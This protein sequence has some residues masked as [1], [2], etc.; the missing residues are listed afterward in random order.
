MQTRESIPAYDN[1]TL[2]ESRREKQNGDISH[3]LA[4]HYVPP[5]PQTHIALLGKAIKPDE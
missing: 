4:V 2:T 5:P 1:A 3:Y